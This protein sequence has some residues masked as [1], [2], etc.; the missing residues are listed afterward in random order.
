[1]KYRDLAGNKKRVIFTKTPILTP[2]YRKTVLF[3]ELTIMHGL[4]SPLSSLQIARI[5]LRFP[6]V[7]NTAIYSDFIPIP[8]IIRLI[9]SLI[10]FRVP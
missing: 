7:L 3:N 10:L 8:L 6:P 2:I 1:M 4:G 5:N 9:L